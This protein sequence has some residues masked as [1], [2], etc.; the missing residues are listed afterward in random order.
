M[1]RAT[2]A[3]LA[4]GVLV[5]TMFGGVSADSQRVEV[6]GAGVAISFPAG[7]DV[8]GTDGSEVWASSRSVTLEPD[9]SATA[10]SRYATDGLI[11]EG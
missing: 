11:C 3:T 1:Q 2:L 6:P 9:G 8:E 7:W 5:A 10:I 4:A